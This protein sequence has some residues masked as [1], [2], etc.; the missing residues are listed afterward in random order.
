[1]KNKQYKD[2]WKTLKE[3][4]MKGFISVAHN[5]LNNKNDTHLQKLANREHAELIYMDK[6]DGTN[7]F[8]S[9]LGELEGNNEKQ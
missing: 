6:L 3:R 1:M 4:K 7:E 5:A 9:L 2:I 8:R